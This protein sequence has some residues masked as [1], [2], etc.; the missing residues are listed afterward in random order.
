MRFHTASPTVQSLT[1]PQNHL[2]TLSE[3]IRCFSNY[4]YFS[5]PS[6]SPNW[7]DRPYFVLQYHQKV[8]GGRW[9]WK[10]KARRKERKIGFVQKKVK[11]PAPRKPSLKFPASRYSNN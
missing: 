3:Q 2:A 4:Y 7:V 9:Y 1:I 6:F 10:E 8:I 5:F 11:D